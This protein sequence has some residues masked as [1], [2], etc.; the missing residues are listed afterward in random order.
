MATKLRSGITVGTLL[1]GVFVIL[2]ISLAASL[3][4]QF[5]QA[6]TEL[7]SARRAGSLAAADAAIFQAT[8]TIRAS[9]GKVQT[10]VVTAADQQDIKELLAQNE[11]QMQAVYRA[12]DGSLAENVTALT[13]QIRQQSST[14][15]A[16]EKDIL[17]AVAKPKAE[18]DIQD[19]K[20]WLKALVP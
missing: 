8:Q 13:S 12:V 1:T 20:D 18:R 19:T 10:L 15:Q 2:A 16:L 7:S 5:T 14:T 6:W 9:R 4:V 11:A 3:T 17:T